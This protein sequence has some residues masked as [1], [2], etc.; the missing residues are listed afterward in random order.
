M[1][2]S[3][4]LEIIFDNS[5]VG[6]LYLRSERKIEKCNHQLANILGYSPAELVGMSMLKLHCTFEKYTEFAER[7]YGRLEEGDQVQVEYPFKRKDGSQVW[8]KLSGKAL[9][10]MKPPDLAKGVLWVVDDITKKKAM[11]VELIE[12]RNELSSIFEGS[13]VGM[14]LL[15]GGRNLAKCNK[16]LS[17]I[18]GY[19][20][21]EEMVGISMLEIHRSERHFI[22][23][24]EKHYNNLSQGEQIQ[25]EYQL[26]RKDGRSVWCT[27]SGKAL[28]TER[29]PDLNKGVLWVV[30]DISKKKAMEVELLESRNELSS[31]F[32]NSQVGMLLLRGGRRLA[33]CN[34]RV[35]DILGYDSPE[36]MVGIS[37]LDI[38]CS[39]RHFIEF[40][41]K[42]YN[43]LSKGE[44]IQVEYQLKRKDGNAVWCIVSGKALDSEQP[45]DLSKGVLWVVDDI[46]E[47]KAMELEVLE[48]KTLA[49]KANQSKSDFLATMS[50]EIRTP[51]NAIIG[52][53]YLMKQTDFVEQQ[54]DYTQKI[55]NS[56]NSLLGIINDI[57]DF[58]KIEAGKLDIERVDFDLYSV[59]ENVSTLIEVKAAEK[60]I[61]FIASYDNA[62]PMELHGDPLRLGQILTNLANNAV[63]FTESGEVGIYI[64]RIAQNRFSFEVRDTGIGLTQEQQGKLFKSF[65]QADTSTTRKYGG[66]GLGLAICK[67]LV[68]L[69]DGDIWV[70]SVPG[71]GS[72][73][74]FEI[75]L[76]QKSEAEARTQVFGGKRVLIV[77]D[78]PSWQD[79]LQGMLI[80]YAIHTEVASSGEEAIAMLCKENQHFD[81]VLMDWHMPGLDGIET[82]KMIREHCETAP[83]TIIMVSA[84]HQET[85]HQAAK[86]QGIDI[87]LHKPINPSLLYNVIV[88]AF[89]EGIKKDYQRKVDTATLKS[90]LTTLKGS[91]IMLVED[92]ALNRE[93]LTGMLQHSGILIEEAH[94]GRQAVDLYR[95]NP[96]KYEFILMDVQMPEMDGYEATRLIREQDQKVPIVA[97]TANAMLQDIRKSKNAGMNEHLNKPI[98][99]EKL[100]GILLKFISKKC[101]ITR[102]DIVQE[103]VA[104]PR[105]LPE[106]RSIDTSVGLGH[107]VDDVALYEKILKNFVYEYR[108]ITSKLY[109]LYTEQDDEAKRITHTI[110]GLSANIGA[111]DLHEIAAKLD[112]TQNPAF[113]DEFDVEIS[114]VILEIEESHLFAAKPP[115]QEKQRISAE[116]LEGIMKALTEAIK[117]R[118][119]QLINPLV[120]E[121]NEFALKPNV[122]E[123]LTSIKPLLSKY[124]YKDALKVLARA[125]YE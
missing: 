41:E 120:D 16:R 78:T 58:S 21:P 71:K 59:V 46:S 76:A 105:A 42:H 69:M 23:F 88:D 56:A 123:V 77:D 1:G 32:E 30:D 12:S 44:Q 97:L 13:Q 100:F 85:L 52:L 112:D 4:E 18:L 111:I 53:S 109:S 2:N 64:K 27:L 73:F 3:S 107:M 45:P 82:T 40:G 115:Q 108:G 74:F 75:E 8:C 19:D 50:H 98:E 103:T 31:I 26:R 10:S 117:K 17:D 104:Q 70:E 15:R 86:D 38:H 93:I 96:E 14:L 72:S 101:E 67:N 102:T 49:E 34:Q 94:T 121:L 36:E 91:Q 22:E 125:G 37:M 48:A 11:E 61:E 79:V 55:E 35:A 118:R 65:S 106:F 20:S 90:E 24:G 29:P 7:Y 119:P 60:N 47:R 99:V 6:L 110:K 43:N 95:D 92:N 63:K 62:V 80:H 113:L 114:Q 83:T 89:G 87:F 5:Q 68:S 124:K 54:Q 116:R 28:D 25:V 57:L 51:I 9:D 39:E 66:T 84:Y 81:L 33:K 122:S